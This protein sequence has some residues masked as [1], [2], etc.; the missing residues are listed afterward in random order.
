MVIGMDEIKKKIILA[1]LL[2]D[3]GKLIYR[4][5]RVPQN[6][7]DLGEKFLSAYGTCDREILRAV[8]YH[9]KGA[10][11]KAQL[12]SNDI[13]Y[14]VYE[15]D[16]IASGTDRRS[17]ESN[18]SG[19]NPEAVL[20]S[21]FN[22]FDKQD[23]KPTGFYLRGLMERDDKMLYPADISEIKAP[24]G[25]YKELQQH[26]EENFRKKAPQDM[27]PNELMQ[28]LEAVM[29]YVPSSTARGE[30]A[31]IS[32]Y[33]H[34]KL[35]G[36]IGACIYDYFQ[37]Q[38]IEDYKK[39][40][41]GSG[42]KEMREN[43]LY[44]LVSAD[45]S[46]IQDFLYTIPSKGALKSLRGRSFYLEILLEHII[47]EILDALE[48]GRCNLLYSGGGNCYL[49][50]PNTDKAIGLLHQA[51]R[52]FNS[53]L[54]KQFGTRLYVAFGWAA[55]CSQDFMAD[56]HNRLGQ[57]Y[58][59]ARAQIA[60]AKH[61]RY[62]LQQLQELFDPLSELNATADGSRECSI[63]HSSTVKLYPYGEATDTLACGSCCGLRELGERLLKYDILVITERPMNGATEYQ[64]EL[65]GLHGNRYLYATSQMDAE[66]YGEHICRIYTKNLMYTG[67]RMAT[68]LWMG[69]YITEI[70]GHTMELEEL[71]KLSGGDIDEN[72]IDRLGVMRADVDNLGAAFMAG[73]PE[74]YATLGRSAALSRQLSMFF[75]RYVN[76]L[77]CGQVNGLNEKNQAQFSMFQRY[78]E[79]QRRV[80]IIYSGGD[81][82]FM[83]G[84]WDDLMELAVDIRGAFRRFTNGKL[85]FS[86]GIGLFDSKCPISEMARASGMLESAAKN[87]P[88][89]LAPQKDSLAM[90]GIPSE[91]S[92][93]GYSIPM[94][95]WQVF[96]QQVC[97]AKLKFCQEHLGYKGNEAPDR[98]V[99]GKGLLYRFLEL[100]N[101]S[102][103][104]INLARFAYMIARL[105]PKKSS[106][107]YESYGKVRSQFY[108]WY[109]QPEH[110]K[111]LM[112]ALELI[113]YSIR[114]KGE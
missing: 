109:S 51:E 70:D 25:A 7:S 63:C 67:R 16:N 36:A 12:A 90:F 99:V 93:S 113:I 60:K 6:H 54:A 96:V 21:V 71:A 10:L 4:A 15:A 78:K 81:D 55:C 75:K 97:G 88:D 64:L 92:H 11:Q 19:Y 1:G 58:R 23:T 98:L 66:K 102:G 106:T 37:A 107:A 73:F 29:S 47:D 95:S 42:Q 31:D 17:N 24:Q 46:G 44:L 52:T 9:H 65:P 82:M 33:D 27:E 41:Y 110:R 57:V 86:A 108:Q 105:E 114:E 111:Q 72:A 74:H 101:D 38:H 53:W 83:V 5:Q 39:Y 3:V 77:C 13:S 87:Y 2:H 48:L 84:A 8:K 61:R 18:E 91:Q 28:V 103:K 69:D 35:T 100:L 22:V 40:C 79:P 26:L 76:V 59:R 62:D 43:P 80:H 45:I 49:L 32:L 20:E 85:S 94:Y 56:N 30:A 68:R 50:L 89:K 112:T 14:I 104:N 34:Q